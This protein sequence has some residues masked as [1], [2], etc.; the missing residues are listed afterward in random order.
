M[1]LYKIKQNTLPN[2]CGNDSKS[3]MSRLNPENFYV[4]KHVS[5]VDV[6]AHNINK[7]E[8]ILLQY[9]K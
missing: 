5:F 3:D 1:I 8:I 4:K 2:S 7:K 9:D 6:S